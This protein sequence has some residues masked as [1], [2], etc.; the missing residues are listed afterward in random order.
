MKNNI[1]SYKIIM[2][3]L[4][5]LAFLG[6]VKDDEGV[7]TPNSNSSRVNSSLYT[8][9]KEWYLWDDKVP[10]LDVSKFSTPEDALKAMMYE[11]LDKWSFIMDTVSFKQ[12]F[13]EGTMVGNGMGMKLD[14]QNNLR[15]TFVYENSPMAKQNI[16][17]GYKILKVNGKSV[18]SLLSNNTFYQEM[19]EDKV[20]ERTS[21]EVEDLQGNV[22]TISV[23][24]EEINLKTVLHRSVLEKG[25]KKVGYLVFNT[26]LEKSNAEL[27]EAFAFFQSQGVSELV[28]DL[29]YN[30]GG[31]LEVANH[32]ASLIGA[33]QT[34]G[35]EFVELTYNAKNTKENKPFIFESTPYNLNLDRLFVIAT[36]S[37][38]SASE[39]IIN[40][41]KPYMPVYVIGDDTHGKP[42]GMNIFIVGKYAVAPI[43]FNVANSNGEAD[44]FDGIKA[45]VYV[46]DNLNYD[47]GDEQES[48]LNQAL[49]Y[50]ENGSFSAPNAR[51]AS[52]LPKN[53]LELTGFRGEVGAF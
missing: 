22:R 24:K 4:V 41:L 38:A 40:G 43:T 19:G 49:Y 14:A 30:G 26:F 33:S 52:D 1:I 39:A 25:G 15:I 17:R 31:S 37:S 21:F 10:A 53:H 47:F 51:V 27:E 12:Y 35:K 11:P 23:T 3:L 6:C 29:R 13:E 36:K 32:L 8:L 50:I 7:A 46:Q 5:A 16:S 45:S 20:G 34:M 28:L 44:Y 9:M 48:S 42:V 2:L 18:S